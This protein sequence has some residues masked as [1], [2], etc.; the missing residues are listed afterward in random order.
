MRF[1]ACG[2]RGLDITDYAY[3]CLSSCVPGGTVRTL[4]DKIGLF[5]HSGFAICSGEEARS[6]DGTFALAFALPIVFWYR[7][8]WAMAPLN[9]R[10]AIQLYSS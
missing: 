6:T 5:H 10:G 1:L 7:P 8:Y 2:T 9:W 3:G 4:S